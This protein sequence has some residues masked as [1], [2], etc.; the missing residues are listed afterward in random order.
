MQRWHTRI[1]LMAT[2][3]VL[4]LG[5]LAAPLTIA[6]AQAHNGGASTPTPIASGKASGDKPAGM[7]LHRG[8][9]L[10]KKKPATSG[11]VPAGAAEVGDDS[12]EASADATSS[13]D[14]KITG[15][16]TTANADA[17]SAASA[18]AKLGSGTNTP[19]AAANS[20]ATSS[21]TVSLSGSGNTGSGTTTGS[22]AGTPTTGGQT[23][24]AKPATTPSSP[25]SS[26]PATSGT[27]VKPTAHATA[28]AEAVVDLR[29]H[30]FNEQVVAEAN[31]DATATA[32]S[33]A[34]AT[35]DATA[36][37]TVNVSYAGG[38]PA[39]STGGSPTGNANGAGTNGG[40]QDVLL[41]AN[42]GSTAD[43]SVST[44]PATGSNGLR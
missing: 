12:V 28:T 29:G 25:M 8:G 5:L 20:A 33:G 10:A 24:A 6:P 40:G 4:A 14:V 26:S 19:S 39:G 13:A 9:Q 41:Q 37:A 32:G 43:A 30:G 44:D 17:R 42:A 23:A 38:A 11:T 18:S 15:G 21:A 31:A 22:P 35:A 16:E 27:T 3:S 34:S 2:A 1:G 36:V 7:S